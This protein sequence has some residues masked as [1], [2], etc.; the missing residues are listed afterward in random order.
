MAKTSKRTLIALVVLTFI[1]AIIVI[2]Y[3]WTKKN[4]KPIIY[5]K[6][7]KAGPA[8]LSPIYEAF[9]DSVLLTLNT[10]QKIA[11]L[12]FF[13]IQPNNK[14]PENINTCG[15]IFISSSQIYHALPIITT[16]H[17]NAKIPV[18]IGTDSEMGPAFGNHPDLIPPDGASILNVSNDSVLEALTMRIANAYKQFRINITFAPNLSLYFHS[19]TLG[20]DL[21]N[22][23]QTYDI[24]HRTLLFHQALSNEGIAVCPIGF[25]N[26]TASYTIPP[27]KKFIPWIE[28]I[29]DSLKKLTLKTLSDSG[30]LALSVKHYPD[31]NTLADRL[32]TKPIVFDSLRRITPF[33]GLVISDLRDRRNDQLYVRKELYPQALLNGSDMLL[34]NDSLAEAMEMIAAEI[35]K[36]I[37][38]AELNQKVKRILMFKAWCGLFRPKVYPEPE[39]L[40]DSTLISWQL[41]AENLYG[42]IMVLARDAQGLIPL[43]DLHLYKPIVIQT[44]NTT[45]PFFIETINQHFPI[46]STWLKPGKDSTYYAEREVYLNEFGTYIVV[47]DSTLFQNSDSLSLKLLKKLNTQKRLIFVWLGTHTFLEKLD[48]FSSVLI[49]YGNNRTAQQV[50]ANMIL[51]AMP[52]KGQLPFTCSNTYCYADGVKR[53][54]T[55]L[56]FNIPEEVGINRQWLLPIDSI[57]Q[58]G[59]IRH[60]MPGCQVFIA[61][62]GKVIWNK[63]YGFHTYEKTQQ[64]Q[65]NDIYDV[66]SV[67]KVA[68]T[69]LAVMKLYDEGKIHLDSTL[70]FYMKELE[71]STLKNVTIKNVLIHQAGFPAVPPVFKFLRALQRF[72]SYKRDTPAEIIKGDTLH[73]YAFS[74]VPHANYSLPVADDIY[75]RNDLLDSI[76]HLVM[77]TKLNLPAEFK[78]SDMSMYVMMK[79][80]EHI[81]QKKLSEFVNEE[82]YRPLI[83]NTTGFNPLTRFEKERIIPTEYD[84]VF[85]RQLIHGHVHDPIAALL[86][87]VSGH[88]GLFSSASDLGILMYMVLNGGS[89]G[90]RKYFSPH[91]VETFTSQQPGTHRALGWD[92]Q[93]PSRSPS[94]ADSASFKTYGHLGFT[95]T[96]VWIDPTYKMVYVFLSNRVYPNAENKKL[97]G[98]RIRQNIHQVI[99]NA[100]KN[101]NKRK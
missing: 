58:S 73:R 67:T 87:G 39:K 6:P 75:M 47:A 63:A 20:Y 80:V 50:A 36:S 81:T 91:T 74:E 54:I 45:I 18:L 11:Q 82:F 40:T 98:L 44:G 59:L 9:A 12:F 35:G 27:F 53:T 86:G 1:T 99:Y 25:S 79:L 29:T 57:I 24:I 52:A 97:M 69:T 85:R 71:K 13:E 84:K 17:T 94:M 7:V 61:I 43:Q 101:R 92:H 60:A 34:I 96:C 22:E 56:K 19:P 41:L 23:Q 38:K 46:T 4:I 68:A 2:G 62:E 66:A 88:A 16:M 5:Q 93:Y 77:Q 51:G 15:G 10:K 32:L 37:S 31:L 55:R 42:E 100:L 48:P 89:Y 49:A 76:W 26:Y 78:Y 33:S 95:G 72:R 70:G 90:G 3:W 14:I 30:L 64:V 8:F 65:L 83:L 28:P 21:Q